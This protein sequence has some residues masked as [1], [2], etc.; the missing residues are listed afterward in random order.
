MSAYCVRSKQSKAQWNTVELFAVLKVPI[1]K[2]NYV[3]YSLSSSYHVLN[4]MTTITTVHWHT[5]KHNSGMLLTT[6][7]MKWELNTDDNIA[8]E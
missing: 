1:Q 2:G 5:L 7:N 3:I 4:K 8:T 6:N